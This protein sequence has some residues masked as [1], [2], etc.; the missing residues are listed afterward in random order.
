MVMVMRHFK[1]G[2]KIHAYDTN[3]EGRLL[4]EINMDADPR[5]R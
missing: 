1:T 5:L 3:N 4:Y 2:R